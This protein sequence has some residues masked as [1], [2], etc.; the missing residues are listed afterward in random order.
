[1]SAKS[2]H[3][4]QWRYEMAEKLNISVSC[5]NNR[6]Y[7]PRISNPIPYPKVKRVNPRVVLVIDQK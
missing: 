3:L 6:L 2:I 7:N 5:L 1:M 4:K